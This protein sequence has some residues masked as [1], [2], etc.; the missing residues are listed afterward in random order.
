MINERKKYV[1]IG[2]G[3]RGCDSYGKVI[4]EDFSDCIELVGLYDINPKRCRVVSEMLG[5]IPAFESFETMMDTVKPDGAVITTVDRFHH[6]YIIKCLDRGVDVIT[7]KPMTIDADKCNAILEAEKRNNRKIKVIFNVRYDPHFVTIKKLI[8][9]GAVGE[10]MNIDYEWLLDT[11]HGAS[12]FRRW[13]R[14][15]E[16]SGGLLVHKATH[17][18]D[19]INWLIEQD[20][21]TVYAN[22]SLS[23]YGKD[24]RPHGERCS[25][26]PYTGQCEFYWKVDDYHQKMY[27]DCESEDGYFRDRCPFDNEINIYD[28]MSLSVKYS[29]GALMSY[30]LI[31]HSPYEGWKLNISGSNGRIEA[32][33]FSSGRDAGSP[34]MQVTV[35]NRDGDVITYDT[36]KVSGSHGGGDAKIMRMLFRNDIPDTLHQAAGSRDG[37]MSVMIGSCANISIREGVPVRVADLVD[38]TKYYP[39]K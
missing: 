39:N 15:M 27:L 10:I 19:I 14:M 20:P 32:N 21:V 38:I 9:S 25:N 37:A 29:K 18:F 36:P 17:H 22:G 33:H 6:E 35:F 31:A 24:R 16:N 4:L 23:F 28:N 11:D 30:S 34:C 13:H 8:Q 5:G 12:Y 7:E 26:C 2:T 3:G 1:I